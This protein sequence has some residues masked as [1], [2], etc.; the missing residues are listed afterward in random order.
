MLTYLLLG[1]RIKSLLHCLFY[2]PVYFI[3]FFN[4]QIFTESLHFSRC[5]EI[6]HNLGNPTGN[7]IIITKIF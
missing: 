5:L 3:H 6:N 2:G 7:Y 4:Q 1:T